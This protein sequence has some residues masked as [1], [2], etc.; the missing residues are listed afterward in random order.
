MKSRSILIAESSWDDECF[1]K[2]FDFDKDVYLHNDYF[3]KSNK[4]NTSFTHRA[5]SFLRILSICFDQK[6]EK[7]F[8]S[9]L[10]FEGYMPALI[11]SFFRKN[12]FFFIPNFFSIY[13][14]SLLMK[15]FFA[16][17]RGKILFSDN[18]SFQIAKKGILLDKHFVLNEPDGNPKDY[19]Y[20]VAMPAAYTHNRIKNKAKKLYEEHL[21]IFNYLNEKN[22]E[23][24]LL[25]HPRD[26]DYENRGLKTISQHEIKNMNQKKVCYVS[27][28]SSLS[29]NK[30]YGGSYG[31][32][33]RVHE[34]STLPTKTRIVKQHIK[35]LSNIIP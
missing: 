8:V 23:T 30:R 25:M 13:D 24:Y 31:F 6:R 28:M 7:I 11:A 2:F 34:N 4:K 20:I 33:C 18:L 15:F 26:R 3:H 32:W 10:N 29:M 21:K 22:L 27:L 14:H 16:A 35:L 1:K 17:F 5:R 12:I 19:I 9:S